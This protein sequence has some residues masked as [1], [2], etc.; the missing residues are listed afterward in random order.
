MKNLVMRNVNFTSGNLFFFLRFKAILRGCWCKKSILLLNNFWVQT[1][2]WIK[3]QFEVSWKF[4]TWKLKLRFWNVLSLFRKVAVGQISE[5][6]YWNTWEMICEEM[7]EKYLKW[8]K[9]SLMFQLKFCRTKARLRI[10]SKFEKIA[11][12]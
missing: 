6:R 9:V 8:I 11:K 4:S 12:Y 10:S 1:V 3:N 5:E 7:L 2:S